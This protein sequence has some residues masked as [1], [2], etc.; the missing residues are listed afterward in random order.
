MMI[1]NQQK[2]TI[3]QKTEW[4]ISCKSQTPKLS[5]THHEKSTTV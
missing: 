5:I 3:G 4:S 2:T 1:S